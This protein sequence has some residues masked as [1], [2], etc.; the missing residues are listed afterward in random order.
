MVDLCCPDT[1]LGL[2]EVSIAEA[3]A[4]MGGLKNRR[5]AAA[6][7][8]TVLL[9]SDCAAAYPILREVP[10]LLSPEVLTRDGP[11]P[12]LHD[13]RWAEAYQEM[14][15]YNLSADEMLADVERE[16]VQVRRLRGAIDEGWIDAPYDAAAQ[17][18]AFER[19]SPLRGKR[20]LQ[21]GGTGSKAVR[22]LVAGADEAVLITPMLG[23]VVYARRLAEACGVAERFTGVVG[24]AEQM[25]LSDAS[26]D[27]IYA[28]G[29]LHHMATQF[30]STEITRVLAPGGAFVAVEP[31]RTALHAVGTWLIGKREANA[32]C[33]PLNAD[34]LAPLRREHGPNLEVRHHGPLLRYA[35]L[36]WMKVR[37]RQIGSA[38][39]L[40]LARWD[41]RLPL[42]DRMGGS[43]TVLISRPTD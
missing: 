39:G 29:C 30:V 7:Y 13:P 22:F 41:D 26:V 5:E 40:R 20:V 32:Y 42:P 28:G 10:I 43:V 19:I 3:V 24:V 27:A 35:A 4:A 31:W 15:F 12:D 23:E 1:G 2:R 18:E 8:E 36:G 33:R 14:G 38:A 34:R 25:P 11:A 6:A 17:M 16:A 9:R 21:L 37:K